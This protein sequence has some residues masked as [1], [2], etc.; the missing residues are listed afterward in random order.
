MARL[1]HEQLQ[2][3]ALNAIEEAAAASHIGPVPRTRALAMTLAWLLH[4]SK[5]AEQLPRWPFESF[6]QGLRV[7]A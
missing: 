5:G 4:F 3:L 1:T 7:R 6:W 2:A